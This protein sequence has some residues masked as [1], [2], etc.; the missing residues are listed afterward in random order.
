MSNDS[1]QILIYRTPQGNSEIEVDLY[2]ESVWLSLNQISTL[3]QRDKSVISRHIKNIFEEGEL[4]QESVVAKKATTGSDKKS[5]Q[6]DFY[7]LDMILSVGYR[8]NS[9]QGTHFRIWATQQLTQYLIKGFVLDDAKLK[10]TK[11]N[12]FDELYE[13]VREIRVSE[14]NFW[15]KVKDI[16]ASTSMD[17]DK[18][19]EIAKKFFA[20]VQNMFHYAIHRHTASELIKERADAYRDNM[21]LYT[22]SGQEITKKDVLVAKNYLTELEIKRLNLLSD[23][24]L[25]FAELQSVERRPMYMA[26]WVGKLIDF[27]KLN[28]KPILTD[29]GKVSAEVGKQIA[30]KEFQKFE[31]KLKQETKKLQSVLKS[32]DIPEEDKIETK[33]QIKESPN[34]SS[35]N[36]VL[37]DAMKKALGGK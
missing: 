1:G 4:Q 21:G 7:N 22:W 2:N 16:F 29:A 20:T 28:E 24:F 23:Q 9:L 6:V 5:Y 14:K 30:M 10:G 32:V 18:E 19:S 15:E 17:Y 31:D 12:Y 35:G 36:S 8:V 13:R 26:T 11:P 37:D 27:L 25:S 3:F 33:S 34:I